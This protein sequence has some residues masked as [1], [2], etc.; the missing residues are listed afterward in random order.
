MTRGRIVA[1]VVGWALVLVPATPAVSST[2][3]SGRWNSDSL[4]DNQVGY[5]FILAPVPGA[6]NVY[7]GHLKFRFQDGRRGDTVP[8][9]ATTDGS[10]VT[11][12]ARSGSLDRSPGV[13]RATTSR[14]GGVITLTNCR[15]RLRLVMVKD[16]ASD[17]TFLPAG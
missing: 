17:C 13:L 12:T 11:I 7:R 4:R 16:L 5:Y 9:R 14:D 1:V 6:G 10:T 15:A 2:D 3:I 8:I